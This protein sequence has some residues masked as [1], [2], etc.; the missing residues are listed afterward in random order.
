MDDETGEVLWSTHYAN[1][2]DG[3]ESAYAI[4]SDSEGNA[5]VTGRAAVTGYGDDI[6]TLKLAA[7]D[8]EVEWDETVHGPSNKD[9]C[10]WSIVVGPDNHPV[11]TGI[12]INADDTANFWT[13]KFDQSDG[14]IIWH[15][16]IPGAVNNQTRAGWL[17]VL[18]NGDIIMANRTWSS[19]TNYDIV[20]H[21]YAAA[22]GAIVWNKQ[23]NGPAAGA[24]DPRNMIRDAAGDIL[25]VGVT[26]GDY[27]IVKFSKDSGD[28]LWTATYD[29]PPGWYDVA[30]CAI[31][32]PNGETIVSGYSSGTTSGWDVVTL[33]LDPD[34][35]AQN[36]SLRHD[37][38]GQ[39]DEARAMAVSQLGDL[40]VTGYSYSPTT[41]MDMLSLRYTMD[42]A[43]DVA[44]GLDTFPVV[45]VLLKAYPNPFNPQVALSF[46]LFRAG[47]THLAIF[48]L[49]G[50]KMATLHEG[51]LEPGH[52]RL[53]WDGRD[54]EGRQLPAG[55]YV[56]KLTGQGQ[57][58]TRKV[59]LAK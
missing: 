1:P 2:G 56:A 42:V 54:A 13:I 57:T 44:P 12:S 40:Y 24:D 34:S 49:R 31:V 35:G 50:R 9:D 18:D 43:A 17:A 6:I 38:A 37:G 14:S 33:G 59:V 8:G 7:S 21:R 41:D 30:T 10:G 48:D 52:H 39:T 46:N 20:L 5:F 22:D 11:I 45:P 36:W 47:P 26:N 29:G 19:S 28:T 55:I 25:V 15:N 4:A 16:P 23:Y 58:T 32:G 51:H 53:N 27:M 3:N